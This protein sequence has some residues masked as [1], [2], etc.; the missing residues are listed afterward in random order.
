MTKATFR[1][2]RVPMTHPSSAINH[3]RVHAS[4]SELIVLP[5][6]AARGRPGNKNKK[7]KT[8]TEVPIIFQG[9][10]RFQL[11]RIIDSCWIPTRGHQRH[12]SPGSAAFRPEHDRS[13][14][15]PR[16]KLLARGPRNACLGRSCWRLFGLDQRHIDQVLAQEPDLKLV[17]AQHFAD[18]EIVRTI[19]AQLGS[20]AGQLTNFANDNLVS[21]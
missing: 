12:L 15:A 10:T 13:G 14:T 3:I 2:L 8:K 21:I 11:Q 7:D 4:L 20:P 1:V 18:N 16:R 9:H 19:I 17:S 5:V 6:A